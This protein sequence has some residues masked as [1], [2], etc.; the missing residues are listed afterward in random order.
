MCNRDMPIETLATI[1]C[2]PYCTYISSECRRWDL[3]TKIQNTIQKMT[4]NEEW[5]RNWIP[6]SYRQPE[7]EKVRL[8]WK[9]CRLNLRINTAGWLD[10]WIQTHTRGYSHKISNCSEPKSLSAEAQT[11]LS[12]LILLTRPHYLLVLFY[13]F[14]FLYLLDFLCY[15]TFSLNSSYIKH[16]PRG[17]QIETSRKMCQSKAIAKRVAPHSQGI[18]WQLHGIDRTFQPFIKQK[19]QIIFRPLEA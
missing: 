19:C 12:H 15:W 13:L 1:K 4:E 10:F 3:S 8:R 16:L 18:D 2:T 6:D 9:T 11:L 17:F 5:N 7:W 14:I